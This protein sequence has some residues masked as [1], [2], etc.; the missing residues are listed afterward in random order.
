M[1]GNPIY[2]TATSSGP[3]KWNGI[4]TSLVPLCLAWQLIFSSSL[5][6]V[7]NIEVAIDNPFSYGSSIAG[8]GGGLAIAPSSQSPYPFVLATLSATTAGQTP[9][10]I[11]FSRVSLSLLNP[12]PESLRFAWLLA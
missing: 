3:S 12:K 4:D 7:A 6:T 9:Q 2:V 10:I 11:T 8:T 1:A 5:G